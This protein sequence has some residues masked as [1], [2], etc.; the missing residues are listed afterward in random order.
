MLPLEYKPIEV[1]IVSQIG[2]VLNFDDTNKIRRSPKFYIVVDPKRRWTIK[3]YNL[4]TMVAQV[5]IDY[6]QFPIRC[7]FCNSLEH[8][9]KDCVHLKVGHL[10]RVSYNF[11]RNVHN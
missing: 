8:L 9:V 3:L 5:S 10:P 6:E 1:T 4:N 2:L 7:K 11:T